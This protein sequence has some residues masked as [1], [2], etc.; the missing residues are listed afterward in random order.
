MTGQ[1][2][3][4]P[5]LPAWWFARLAIDDPG[6]IQ[7]VHIDDPTRRMWGVFDSTDSSLALVQDDE[8]LVWNDDGSAGDRLRRFLDADPLDLTQ[9]VVEVSALGAPAAQ[10]AVVLP[11]RD[12][13]FAIS[14]LR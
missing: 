8:L 12:H 9:V 7:L 13:Q 2:K 5:A 1:R 3:R 10:R 11:R 4:L 14:G 6:A